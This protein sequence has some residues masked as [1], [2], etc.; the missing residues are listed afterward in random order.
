VQFK[1][2]ADGSPSRI[3]LSPDGKVVALSSGTSLAFYSVETG[4]CEATFTG[5]HS[6]KYACLLC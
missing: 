2:A 1:P 4:K 3:A 6:G 5:V